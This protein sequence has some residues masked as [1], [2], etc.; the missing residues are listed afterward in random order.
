MGKKTND[1]K[2]QLFLVK[3]IQEDLQEIESYD[4]H[5]ALDKVEKR[6]DK[7]ISR[8]RFLRTIGKVAAVVLIPLFIGTSVLSYLYVKNVYF[9][10]TDYAEI[11]YY[12]VS[13]APGVIT[14]VELPDQ[15]KVW[16]NSMSTLRYPAKFSD[17]ERC[18]FLTGEGFFEVTSDTDYPFYVEVSEGNRVKA[19]GT[20]F[21]V[22]AYNNDSF[23]ETV[24]SSGLV[25]VEINRQ[26]VPIKPG[27]M[28]FYNMTERRVVISKVNVE[29]KLA[30][31]DGWLIFRNASIEEITK[32]LSRR[33]NVDF[34]VQK[35]SLVEYRFRASF[36]KETL[37]QTLEYLSQAAPIEW[38]FQEGIQQSDMTY[39]R[40]RIILTIK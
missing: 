18:V 34:I 7:S 36:M 39:S 1:I 27:E 17:D 35:E 22:S 9:E 32:K 38:S 29:E 28:A 19:Y 31:K 40:Q 23:V 14:Q 16:L 26:T 33:Y 5:G 6:I 11:P 15:S 2:G 8:K 20:E 24:L 13:S 21:N 10:K 4:V 12:T 25:D 3:S 37:M 30:W